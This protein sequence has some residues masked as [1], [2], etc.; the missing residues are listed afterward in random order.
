MMMTMT[1]MKTMSN[2]FKEIDM[3]LQIR[4]FYVNMK[5]IGNKNGRQE[6]FHRSYSISTLYREVTDT[7]KQAMIREYTEELKRNYVKSPLVNIE[8]IKSSFRT[9]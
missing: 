3:V 5:A 8:S 7:E 4:N 6:K 2:N 1:M 9:S